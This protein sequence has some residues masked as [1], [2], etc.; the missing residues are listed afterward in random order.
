MRTAADGIA[1]ALS[2][3][4][5]AS[6]VTSDWAVQRHLLQAY[7]SL[8][9]ARRISAADAL[10]VRGQHEKHEKSAAVGSAVVRHC[11]PQHRLAR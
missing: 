4:L 11:Q 10:F 2:G 7:D 1:E 3:I 8:Q 6:R 9:A 5:T